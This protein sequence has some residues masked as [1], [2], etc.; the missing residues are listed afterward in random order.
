MYLRHALIFAPSQQTHVPFLMMS[1][2]Y[3]RNFG[4]DRQCLNALAERTMCRGQRLFHTT[5]GHAERQ[6]R[7]YQSR[8]DILQRSAT[9]RKRLTSSC[10][11]GTMV[12]R[13]IGVLCA[14]HSR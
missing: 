2:D 5:A 10:R 1:A 7:E 13:Q 6:S 12:R 14:G 9:R 11:W 8:L 3:Q 4:V